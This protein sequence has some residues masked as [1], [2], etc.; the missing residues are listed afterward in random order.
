MELMIPEPRWVPEEWEDGTFGIQA[1]YCYQGNEVVE[2]LR[3]HK[4][5]P[6]AIQYMASFLK[7]ADVLIPHTKH[8]VWV[9]WYEG[10]D[11]V[12]L[13]NRVRFNADAIQYL[14]DM[15]EV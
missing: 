15:L 12:K 14:A 2:L 11:V 1:G 3:E 5:N 8:G 6:D 10:K 4:E 7:E 13:L 9:G